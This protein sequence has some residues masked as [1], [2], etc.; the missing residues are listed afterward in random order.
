V[1]AFKIVQRNNQFGN[2]KLKI[3]GDCTTPHAQKLKHYVNQI[4]AEH[5]EFTDNLSGKEVARLLA[6]SLISVIPSLW[7]ENMPNAILES[8][9]SGTPVIASNIG[10]FTEILAEGD[11]GLLFEVGNSKD[12]AIK[13][14]ELLSDPERL[15]IMAKHARYKAEQ[16]YNSNL[17]YQRLINLFDNFIQ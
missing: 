2:I 4:N 16:L 13:I 3:A 5:I 11:E 8:L 15:N 12:L 17:H 6:K 10:S 1:E 14:T 9:A 7:Y